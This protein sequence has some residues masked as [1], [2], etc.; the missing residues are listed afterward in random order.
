MATTNLIHE[1][2]FD[3]LQRLYAAASHAGYMA[4]RAVVEGTVGSEQDACT[5]LRDFQDVA[6][7]LFPLDMA[8]LL[9]NCVDAATS[10]SNEYGF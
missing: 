3:D 9:V 10:R 4:D 5:A 8:E 6:R 7:D 2:G 1:T